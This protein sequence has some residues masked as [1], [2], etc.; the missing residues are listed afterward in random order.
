M[1]DAP[2][3]ATVPQ[4]NLHILGFEPDWGRQSPQAEAG[5]PQADPIE[6]VQPAAGPL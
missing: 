2:R 3:S 4:D 5:R 1:R 6:L